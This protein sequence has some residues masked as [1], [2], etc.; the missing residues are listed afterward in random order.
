MVLTC[1]SAKNEL[2]RGLQCVVDFQSRLPRPDYDYLEGLLLAL[3]QNL[4]DIREG[5]NKEFSA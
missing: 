5:Y 3:S 1:Q 4:R 2:R